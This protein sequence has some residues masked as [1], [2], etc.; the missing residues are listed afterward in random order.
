M[1]DAASCL[2]MVLFLPLL[3]SVTIVAIGRR[4][5]P[6][7]CH[8][9]CIA[10]AVGACVFAILTL[11]AVTAGEPVVAGRDIATDA[12]RPA[13]GGDGEPPGFRVG[14]CLRLGRRDGLYG[15]QNGRE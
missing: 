7:Y 9:P 14:R 3:G 4:W 6:Q 12:Q 13:V 10:G 15:C 11:A 8:I 1:F 2:W 5:F